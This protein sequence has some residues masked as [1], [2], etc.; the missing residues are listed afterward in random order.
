MSSESDV[1]EAV[2]RQEHGRIIAA[3]IRY[4]GDFDVAEEALQDAFA[5]ALDRW[6]QDGIPDNPAAWITTAAKRTAINR[7]RREQVRSIKYAA[8]NGGYRADQEGH[9]V[10]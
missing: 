4:F 7:L 8:L 2:F 10:L 5:A 6:P 3:L 1:V 9:D